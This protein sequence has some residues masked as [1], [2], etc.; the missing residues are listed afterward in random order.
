MEELKS[1]CDR[2]VECG[3]LAGMNVL[4][5]KDGTEAAYYQNGYR[6]VLNGLPIERNTIFRLYSMSK[7]VTAAAA[8]ILIERGLLSYDEPVSKYLPT[9]KNLKVVE[10]NRLVPAEREITIRDLMGMQSGM[11]YGG[12]SLAGRHAEAVFNEAAETVDTTGTLSTR[13]FA[14]KL[15][16]GA[17]E[18]QP[19]SHWMY[20]SSADIMGAVIEAASGKRFGE[21]LQEEIFGPLGMKDT[22]FYVPEEKRDRFSKSYT[23]NEAG[24]LIEFP[25]TH[26]GISYTWANVPSFES[27]GAGLVSTIEDY[28]KF[29]MMLLSGGKYNDRRI[30]RRKTVEHMRQSQMMP[31]HEKDMWD[32][33]RGYGYGNFMRSLQNPGQSM[34]LGCKEEFG[35][36]GWLGCYFAI[37]PVENIVILAMRQMDGAGTDYVVREL[38]NVILSHLAE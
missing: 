13:E 20:G 5:M 17:A 23:H 6:D 16:E 24:E 25:T 38:R 8:M 32:G 4:V 7:P 33:L 9:F 28:K 12:T 19:G 34:D 30:L 10:E 1:V 29:C 15:G 22:G 3:Y 18:F 26:L 27:G 36:D 11:P 2:A 31:W 14:L 21:F 35:W 37:M